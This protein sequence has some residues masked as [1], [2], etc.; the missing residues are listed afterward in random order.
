MTFMN[1]EATS[2]VQNTALL[3]GSERYRQM[4]A[5][6]MSAHWLG[7]GSIDKRVRKQLDVCLN[8]HYVTK[9]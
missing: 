8:Q 3:L 9:D 7:I 4:D 2:F 6:I 5:T 1:I